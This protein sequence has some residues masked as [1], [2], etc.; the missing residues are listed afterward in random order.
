MQDAMRFVRRL[1]P[2]A[3]PS[4]G[5]RF[6]VRRAFER[7]AWRVHDNFATARGRG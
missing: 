4:C 7:H 6:R 5:R 1:L 3:C 2:Y